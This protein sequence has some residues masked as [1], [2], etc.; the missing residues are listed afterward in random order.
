ME[1]KWAKTVSWTELCERLG[2]GGR[3]GTIYR[4]DEH[5]QD[6]KMIQSDTVWSEC[7]V[8][9]WFADEN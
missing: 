8:V 7:C 9:T 6:L 4:C 5:L 1:Q 3:Q 2:E